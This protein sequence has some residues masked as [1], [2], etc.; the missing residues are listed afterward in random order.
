MDGFKGFK[1]VFVEKGYFLVK[2][3]W[4]GFVVLNVDGEVLFVFCW[5]GIKIKVVKEKLGDFE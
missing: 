4:W 5:L 1:V 2:G 3:D